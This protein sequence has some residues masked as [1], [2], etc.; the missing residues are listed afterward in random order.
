MAVIG[1]PVAT[2][3]LVAAAARRR[4]LVSTLLLAYLAYVANLGLV[5]LALSPF[6]E[7]TRTGL[8]AAEALACAGA[9]LV[10]A[11]RGRPGLPVG[12][13]LAAVREALSDPVTA[14]FLAVT[15]LLLAYELLLALTVPPN[16]GDALDYHLPRAA[17]WAQNGGIYWIPQAPNVFLNAYQP[18]AEQQILFLLVAAG[19]SA[20]IALPQYLAELAILLSVSGASRRLGFETRAA[21]CAACLLATF[22]V[23]ALESTTAQNDLVVASFAAVAATLLLGSGA[24]EAAA[25]GAA[26]AFGLGTKL[27]FGLALPVLLALAVVRGRRVLATALAGGVAGF[28]AVGM[29]G[30]VQNAVHTGHLLG[31]GTG[32]YQ[33]RG[34]PSYPGSVANAFYFLYRLLDAS[35]LS[36]R[37]IH[38]LA[39]LGVLAA[40]AVSVVGLRRAPVR[41]RLEDALGVATPLLAPLLVIGGAGL[42]SYLAGRF[43]FP[44]RGRHGI[45]APLEKNLNEEYG[46]IANEDYSAFGPVGI[47]ALLAASALT[48][49]GFLARRLDP[50]HL[51]LA[52]AL[53]VF[54]ILI[55]LWS[56]WV[57]FLIRFF[58]LP[59]VLAAPLLACLFRRRVT[60]AA[61]L[62]VA[63]V[64][65]G[66][67]I[68]HDQTKPLTSANGFGRPWSLTQVQALQTNSR[69]EYAAALASYDRVVPSHACVG[70][71]LARWEPSYLLFGPNLQH[72]VVFL[73]V[74]HSLTPQVIREHLFY[75]VVSTA[76]DRWP[77]I[78]ELEGEGW[79]VRNLGPLWLLAISPFPGAATGDCFHA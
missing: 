55:S 13:A 2:A 31:L 62:A 29:W 28:A 60:G 56:T 53:P 54:L 45:L 71:V 19:S 25:A 39:L 49:R 40:A 73:D 36:S 24:L 12:S 74:T 57:P 14:L 67:T 69:V 46:R 48:I 51:V 20:L 22:S 50:R 68:T 42:V 6:H 47:V 75:V 10:W 70:A 16:N 5:T 41:R 64:A 66:L 77:Q 79:R 72:R 43:G 78:H 33:D 9:L 59:A 38:L 35:V 44:I 26:A 27:S 11:L 58:L 37:L 65:I 32:A 15:L 63:A 7:V 1:L 30:Y 23:V 76:V 34:S 4:S 8:G 21:A 3:L 61:Y 52:C 18:L 17:A